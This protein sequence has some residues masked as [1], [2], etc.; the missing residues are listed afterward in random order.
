MEFAVD[1]VTGAG[2]GGAGYASSA[3]MSVAEPRNTRWEKKLRP[4]NVNFRL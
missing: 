1:K 2:Y 3:G 4:Q